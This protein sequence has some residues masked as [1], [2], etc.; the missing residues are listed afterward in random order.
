[1][2]KEEPKEDDKDSEVF[3]HN[4][5][6]KT[7]PFVGPETHVDEWE[8]TQGGLYDRAILFGVFSGRDLDLDDIVQSIG[9]G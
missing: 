3:R 5:G 1:M 6:P 9:F 7:H 4:I 2:T 8:K